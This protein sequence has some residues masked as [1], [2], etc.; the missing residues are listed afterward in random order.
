MRER[1]KVQEIQRA[2]PNQVPLLRKKFLDVAMSYIG[3]PYAQK[4]HT[5]DCEY[6]QL[7]VEV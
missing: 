5:A 6:V 1:L 2:E 3:V 7:A 4:Y